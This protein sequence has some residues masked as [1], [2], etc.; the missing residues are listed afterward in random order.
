MDTTGKLLFFNGTIPELVDK[1][2][3][4]IECINTTKSAL[5]GKDNGSV[6]SGS[7]DVTRLSHY[8]LQTCDYYES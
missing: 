5:G 4:N 3:K 1:L 6:V 7:V 8:P 2:L